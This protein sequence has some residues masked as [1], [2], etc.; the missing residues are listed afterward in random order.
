[1]ALGEADATEPIPEPVFDPGSSDDDEA[2]TIEAAGDELA[3]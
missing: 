3:A 1:M 2:E